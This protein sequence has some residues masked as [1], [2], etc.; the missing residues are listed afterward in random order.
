MAGQIHQQPVE[1][2]VVPEAVAVE[3]H[4]DIP[5]TKKTDEVVSSFQGGSL[6]FPQE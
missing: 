6:V 4:I 2:S 3:F 5:R 1:S